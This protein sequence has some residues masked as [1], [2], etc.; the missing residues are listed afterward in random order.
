MNP[1]DKIRELMAAGET[2][3]LE[4][5]RTCLSDHQHLEVVSVDEKWIQVQKSN[6]GQPFFIR[7]KSILEL[8]VMED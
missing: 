3:W 8:T 2:F 6:S 1:I 7:L 5:V 4:D